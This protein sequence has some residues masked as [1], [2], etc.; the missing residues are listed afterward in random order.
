[1]YIQMILETNQ[2]DISFFHR[3]SQLQVINHSVHPKYAED[4]RG[5][6]T[7]PRAVIGGS[8]DHVISLF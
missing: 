2:Y 4:G 7:K 6:R 5:M 3:L 1:M 8:Q